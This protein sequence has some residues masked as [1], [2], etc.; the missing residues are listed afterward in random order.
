MKQYTWKDGSTYYELPRIIDNTSPVTEAWWVA[1]GGSI[2]EVPDPPEPIPDTTERDNAEKAIVAQFAEL[3]L[4][5]NALDDL[6]SLEE[7]SIPSL[8][9][10]AQEKNVTSEHLQYT[11]C[12][13]QIYVLQLEA[14]TG[15]TWAGCWEGLRSRF[16]Q[17][18]NE[19]NQTRAEAIA[20]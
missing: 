11:M 18:L 14:V 20:D 2:T 1:N 4:L 19:W 7:I 12:T 15:D 13:V 5:Y 8:L 9:A 16:A 10:L 17:W 6:A 3:A